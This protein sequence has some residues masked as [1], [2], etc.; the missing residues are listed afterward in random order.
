MNPA[1]LHGLPEP[2]GLYHPQNEHD[3]CGIGFVVNIKNEPSHE[4]ITKGIQ[5]LVNLTHRGACGCDPETG[6]GAGILIQIPHKFFAKECETLGFRLPPAGEYGIGMMFLPV[7][8]QQRLMC[9]GI[10]ER[11]AREQGLTPLGWR[12]TPTHGNTIG[13]EA[14]ATQPYI[15]Q[16][17]IG[18]ASGMSADEFERRL[19]IVRK[20]AEAEVA[21]SDLKEKGFFYVPSLSSRI[22]VY[23]GL[24]LAPQISEFYRELKDPDVMSAL[25]LVHQRFST[26]TFPSWNLAHPYRYVCHNGEINTVKGNVNWM[27]ARQSV[28]GSPHFGDNLKKMFP[29]IQPGGSDSACLDNAV[30][31]LAMS[32]RELPHVMAML[33]PEAWDADATMS[34]EKRAFYEYHASLMEP[35]DGP[36]AVAFADGRWIGATLDRNGLRPARYV[37]TNDDIVIMASETGVLPVKPENIKA[38]GRLQ[39]GRMFLVDLE[40]KRIVPDEEIKA[41]LSGRRPYGEWIQKNQ[42]L[43]DHLP[44][45]SRVLE[46]DHDTIIA[47]QRAFGYTEEDIRMLMMPMANGGEEPIGSMGTDTPLA[48]LSDKPQPLFNYFK[49]LF[50][51]VTNPAIDPIREELVMSLTS[52]IGN[53]RNILDETPEHCHTLKLP[54]PI[55]TNRDLEKL[56]R[57]SQGDFLATTLPML[58]LVDEGEKGLRRALD[59]LCRRASLAIKSGYTL[60]ILSDRGID[61]E[62][63]PIPSL[64]ALTAVHNHLVREGTRTQV[65][66]VIES[67]EPREVMH[68]CLLIGYGASAINPYLAIET[69]EDLAKR[70]GTDFA[71][72]LKNYKKA[73]NKGLLK[74]FSKMGISTLQSYRGAQVFEAIGLNQDLIDRYFTGTASRIE[75]VGLDVLAREAQL[76]HAH[77][78]QKASENDTELD[79]GG[80]YHYRVRGEYHLF[81]PTTVS[82]LQHAVTQSKFETFQEYTKA[83]DDQSKHLCTLRG[84]MDLRLSAKPI[85]IEEVEPA[86]EIVKRFATGAMSFGSISKEAHETLAIAMNRI[87]GRSNTGEGGEDAERF[88]PAPN[89]DSRRSSIKQVA[90]GR[91]GVTTEYLVNADELQIKVAQGAKPGE[92]GQ[93]PGHKVDENIA[94]VRHSIPGVGLISPPPHH[95]IYSIEDL[96]QLIY[97]LKNTNPD[98]RISVKLVAEVGVGTVAAGVAKAHA[99][100]V[101]ISGH[102][103]GTGASPLTS[104]KHAGIPWELG[105]AETQQVLVL[106]DLRSRIRVQTDGKLQ[107]GRDVVIAALLGAEEFGFSTAPLVTMGCIMMRKCHLNTCPVGIATQDPDLRKKFTGKPEH[108]INFF[109]YIAEEVRQLMAKLGFRKMDEM[110]GRVDMIEMRKAIDHWKARGLDFSQILHNPAVPGRVGRRCLISQDHGLEQAL[111]YKLIDNARDAIEL[112]TPVEFKLPIKNVHRTVGAMLSGQIAKKYGAEGLPHDTIRFEFNG[113]AGQSFG[114]F[115]AKGVTL[116]LEGDANDYVGKGL[117][118]GRIIVYPPRQSN[119]LPEKNILI[120]NVVLYGATTGECFFNGVAGERFAVRN[121]GATAVVEGVGDHGCEY[122]TKGLVVILGETGKNFGAGMSGGVAFVLDETGKFSSTLCN[123]SMVDLEPVADPSDINA[124]RN[125]IDRH[126]KLTASPRAQW[127]LENF[128]TML[129]LFVKVFPHEY[130]RVLGVPRV[131]E[132]YSPVIS[133]GNQQQQQEGA[134]RG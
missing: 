98:A 35:W 69:L 46:T 130:K 42:I 31:L 13:R 133:G 96:A 20:M 26:N 30:E 80:Q 106:N 8:R 118:G 41:K 93:L 97:D 107:T 72:A 95:D 124:L 21:E 2:Q 63:A 74:V 9:E 17:F 102:D 114:A 48:C 112:G 25:C 45:P 117:S 101:L 75:G 83:I 76:K 85:P 51:Q 66:L 128:D 14:R 105:L 39:P 94:R 43:L 7:E 104:L 81:N 61:E 84:L 122:M 32:G 68:Y 47:R 18:K 78:Y 70:G 37:V 1:H 100:L 65:A 29:I 125:L 62:S 134:V 4:I 71:T 89:G 50:A 111:D 60:I 131:K 82:K 110:I 77:A 10:I 132:Q 108:V 103:G 123:K 38:K 126:A 90:S 73:V 127:I 44:E 5:I 129:P 88:I 33:M 36:A 116:T 3:A 115:L 119:F 67:G 58:F 56:R 23:K 87:G 6:D 53:E 12:D 92:G 49:Q 22:I 34:A 11:L 79:V 15:E 27:H 113:S 99:D 52:Y 91:F 121:S 24:L 109:F 64:L 120:G 59:G 57:L 55:L 28:L 86:S 54:H 16:V 40:E 19:Y